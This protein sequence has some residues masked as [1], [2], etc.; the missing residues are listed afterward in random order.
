MV[1]KQHHALIDL[2]N[3]FGDLLTQPDDAPQ[4]EAD[5]VLREAERC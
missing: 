5:R 1:D 4:D 2:M 3:R